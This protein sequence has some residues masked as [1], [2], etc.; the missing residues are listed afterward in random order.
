V[1]LGFIFAIHTTTASEGTVAVIEKEDDSSSILPPLESSDQA[2]EVD[3][4]AQFSSGGKGGD[5]M[6]ELLNWATTHSDPERVK[7]LMKKYQ[8]TNL[9]IKDIY[10]QEVFD[11]L[12]VDEGGVMKEAIAELRQIRNESV[13][14]EDL[15]KALWRLQEMVEQVDNAGNLH[16]MGGLE[17]LLDLAAGTQRSSDLRTLALWT[18]GVA[19]QNNAP[20]QADLHSLDG[21]SR[22]VPLLERCGTPEAPAFVEGA[23]Y[24]GKLIYCLSGLTRNDLAAQAS[25]DKLGLFLWLVDVG[26]RSASPAVSKKSI[27][28]LDITLAQSPDLPFLNSLATR[29]EALTATFMGLIGKP[30]VD[31]AEKA[32]NVV[33]RLLSLRPFLFGDGFRAKLA[34]SA[35]TAVGNCERV[36][37]VGDELCTGIAELAETADSALA[38]QELPDDSL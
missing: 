11:A 15:E 28:L 12:F 19:V 17:P 20:V 13:P 27:G 4:S 10:G 26:I 1:T 9:T 14:D 36:N 6:Q 18:L 5:V 31:H 7:E 38:A 3:D 37:S 25:A 8:D 22:L 24:C 30:D 29:R 21:L 23:D 16:R 34:D 2:D 35:R 33:T 32:L